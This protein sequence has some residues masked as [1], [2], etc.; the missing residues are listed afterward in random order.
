MFTIGEFSRLSH[1]SARMLRHYDAIGLLSPAQVGE[2]GYRYYTRE[3]L[4]QLSRI[5]TLKGYGF[6]L[7]EVRALLSLPEGEL[8]QRLRIRRCEAHKELQAMRRAIRQMEDAMMEMEGI[9]MAKERYH[10]IELYSPAQKVFGIRRT[11]DVAKTHAL[12]QE[13]E[14]ERKARGYARTGVTQQMYLGEEFNHTA[15][16]VEAQV[17]VEGE[18]PGIHTIPA[19]TYVAVT[20]V[21]PYETI[22]YAYEAIAAY[23]GEHP[24]CQVCGPS[25]ERYLKDEGMAASSEELETAVLF[26][27]RRLQSVEKPATM[28]LQR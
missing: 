14:E 5:E 13:L 2:N 17:E 20:H 22:Q 24:D 27:I 21:G 1:I 16:D 8:A 15:M 19:C 18:G 23:L 28:G 25:V 3:Q 11:I 4:A 6:S 26:P 7:G 10:V 12:F 9:T